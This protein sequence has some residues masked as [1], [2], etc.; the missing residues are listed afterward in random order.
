MALLLRN[1][2]A[3]L[4]TSGYLAS[5][6]EIGKEN[7]VDLID[8]QHNINGQGHNVLSE[9]AHNGKTNVGPMG[10]ELDHSLSP[11]K[12]LQKNCESTCSTADPSGDV[13]PHII[14]IDISHC[15]Q[16]VA[17]VSS[18]KNLLVWSVNSFELMNAR[19]VA[20]KPSRVRFTP[21]SNEILVADKSGSLYSFPLLDDGTDGK[22][23]LAHLSMLLDVV[24]TP[25][26]KF[27][28]TCD[29]DEKIRVSYWTA[30][31][32]IQSFCQGHREFVSVISLLPSNPSIL[33]SGSGD[34]T[35]RFWDYYDG[36]ELESLHCHTIYGG[37]ECEQKSPAVKS[38]SMQCLNDKDMLCVCLSEFPGSLVY[39]IEMQNMQIDIKFIK[40]ITYAAEPMCL[41]LDSSSIV[42][43]VIPTNGNKALVECFSLKVGLNEDTKLTVSKINERKGFLRESLRIPSIIPQLFK[44][45]YETQSGEAETV[46][47]PPPK[48]AKQSYDDEGAT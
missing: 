18:E 29:R 44:K 22:L 30:P 28:I 42:W 2:N 27:V 25:D 48:K 9:L 36:V 1:G 4:L 41:L 37:D 11:S 45:K 16:Y 39:E 38:F 8:S 10:E 17:M 47:G 33:V 14:S 5:V 15:G 26:E 7:H 31:Y 13:P 40:K 19:N 20:R 46:N 24:V 6:F 21:L 32:N 43:G 35:V 23:I 3:V 34:G 12:S